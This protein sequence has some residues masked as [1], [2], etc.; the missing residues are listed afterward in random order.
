MDIILV[1]CVYLQRIVYYTTITRTYKIVFNDYIYLF[2]L[3][4]RGKKNPLFS[5]VF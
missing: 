5:Y 3:P 1:K 4:G 2:F